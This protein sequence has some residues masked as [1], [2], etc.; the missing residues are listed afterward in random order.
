MC[1]VYV[2]CSDVLIIDWESVIGHFL[3]FGMVSR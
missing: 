1:V 3:N 2:V